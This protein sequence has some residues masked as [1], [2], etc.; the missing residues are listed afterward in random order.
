MLAR[1]KLAL[2]ALGGL[3]VAIVAA[4]ALGKRAARNEATVDALKDQLETRR[5]MDD[6]DVSRS[7]P[8]ADL[9]WLRNRAKR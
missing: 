8:V 4:F 6:A 3:I 5:K 9:D 2:A 7:D 1:I